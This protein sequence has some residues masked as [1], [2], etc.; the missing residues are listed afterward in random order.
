METGVPGVEAP[1]GKG[2][3]ITGAAGRSKTI[4]WVMGESEGCWQ[5]A[6]VQSIAA[7]LD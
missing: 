7:V 5:Q 4:A 2:A 6:I 3:E 1:A